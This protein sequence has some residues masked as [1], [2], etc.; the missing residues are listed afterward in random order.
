MSQEQIEESLTL[1]LSNIA[2][3]SLCEGE[4]ALVPND[5]QLGPH[6]AAVDAGHGITLLHGGGVDATESEKVEDEGINRLVGQGVLLLEQGLNE[7][8]GGAAAFAV[9]RCLLGGNV[10]QALDGS[11]RVQNRHGDS[12]QD[13][14]D[15]VGF[16]DGAAAAADQREEE[17]LEE[18]GGLVEGLLQRVEQ[19]NVELLIF[20]N[21]FADLFEHDEFEESLDDAGLGR[22]ED[23]GG[24]VARVGGPFL[25]FR[26][27]ENIFPVRDCGQNLEGLWQRARLVAGQNIANPKFG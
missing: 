7:E 17:S 20:V 4:Q 3:V 2:L 26:N 21:V 15:D 18:G 8:V 14:R 22:D 24:L 19:V 27:V 16:A 5:R 9:L 10:A 23:A 1:V 6:I 12:G 11:G 25:G 13:S